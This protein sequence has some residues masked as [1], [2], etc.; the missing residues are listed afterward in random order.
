MAQKLETNTASM[1][2]AKLAASSKMTVPNYKLNHA[3][4]WPVAPRII[5]A[6]QKPAVVAL[7]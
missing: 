3:T 1:R 5:R 4:L 6:K 7:N 2:L